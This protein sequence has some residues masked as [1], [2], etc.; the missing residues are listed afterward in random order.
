MCVSAL[1]AGGTGGKI[2]FFNG[3]NL[4]IKPNKKYG[5]KKIRGQHLGTIRACKPRIRSIDSLPEVGGAEGNNYCIYGPRAA[6][7]SFDEKTRHP[8][9]YIHIYIYICVCTYTYIHTCVCTY[10]Y[11]HIHR[12]VCAY[13]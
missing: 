7:V 3:K 5:P 4:L 13:T 2:S 11:V 10:V 1:E 6:V 8:S 9:I 12:D